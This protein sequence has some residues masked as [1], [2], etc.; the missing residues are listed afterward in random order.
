MAESNRFI[1]NLADLHELKRGIEQ[2]VK[3]AGRLQSL[4][5]IAENEEA[6]C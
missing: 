6:K 2:N 5:L 1:D 3:W 4:K